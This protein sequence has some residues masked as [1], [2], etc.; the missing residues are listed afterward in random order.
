MKIQRDIYL[1]QLVDGMG[2]DM[3]KV[4]TGLRR[5]GKTY[6][7]TTLFHEYLLSR[8]ISE[9]HIIEL[10]L[11]VWANRELR[12]PDALFGYVNARLTGNGVHYLILD[13]VQMLEH[14]EEVLNSLLHVRN[15]DIYVTGSNSRFLST[16]VITEFRGRGDEIRIHPL[17]YREFAS[18]FAEESETVWEEFL[19]YGGMPSVLALP[20]PQKK[21]EYL[22]HLVRN[23]FMTDIRDRRK[24]R[25]EAELEEL[26]E[27]LFS[28]IG[29]LV[30]PRK[31]ANTFRSVKGKKIETKTLGRYL[32]Y[33]QEA[34]LMNRCRRFDVK[35]RKY[36]ST[37]AKFY[38]EDVGL[39]NA[40]L[41]FRQVE[42]SHLMENILYN[43]L[44]IRGFEV[45]V[46]V[47]PL[48]VRDRDGRHSVRRMEVD[49]VANKGNRRYY[50]Q[51]A[52]DMPTAEKRAQEERP[53]ASIPDMFRKIIVTGDNFGPRLNDRGI[54]TMGIRKFLLDANSLDA[55]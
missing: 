21:S 39:R 48:N 1:K 2:N 28:S 46:G 41:G 13:E 3:V 43:E 50:V 27:V 45:D 38:A 5:C 19:T 52:L 32:L 26:L 29:S 18:A 51:S 22:L 4:V 15:L 23:V 9:D 6:L 16:D 11:D 10:A 25:N 34:F 35:G 54:M 37:P 33:L 20:S 30:N 14:F 7:L 36:I 49:F 40:M 17:C 44:R 24:V 31:L 8:G 12:K 55:L 53:L 47:I 42:Y